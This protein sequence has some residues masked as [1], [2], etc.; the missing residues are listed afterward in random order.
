MH[1]TIVVSK[2]F[3][4]QFSGYINPAQVH[5]P[6][7]KVKGAAVL[8][9]E[10]VGNCGS[11]C[12]ANAEGWKRNCRKLEYQNRNLTSETKKRAVDKRKSKDGRHTGKT[13]VRNG[14]E[15]GKK[16]DTESRVAKT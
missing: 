10:E 4:V 12:E 1:P 13:T 11:T 7:A 5:E 15:E 9:D 2:R 3:D 6:K 8:R 14:R 16:R